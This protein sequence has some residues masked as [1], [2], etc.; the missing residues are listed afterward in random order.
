MWLAILLALQGAADG[1]RLVGVFEGW[2]AFADAAPRRCYAIAQ[3][4]KGGGPGFASVTTWPGAGARNQLHVRLSRPR[5]SG[6]R[7]TLA[8]GER[9]F[10][11]V[12]GAADAWAPDAATD[13]AIAAAMRGG[14]AMSVES[15]ANT[16]TPFADLYV[17]TGAAT[18]IDAAAVACAR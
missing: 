18:A 9:R 10:A 17:L 7:V 6:A 1:R 4:G 2:G 11:L 5:S 12:S 15:V 16:G 14:R 8:I 13:R 3:P